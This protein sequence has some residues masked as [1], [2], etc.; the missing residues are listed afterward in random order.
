MGFAT[1]KLDSSLFIWKGR[2]EQVSILLYVDDLVITGADLGE[3][4][5]VKL[6]L[7]A[8]FDMQF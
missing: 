3:I 2:L 7:A 5:L 1:S 6:Q 4:N 8:S